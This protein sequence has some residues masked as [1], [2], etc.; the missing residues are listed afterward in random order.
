MVGMVVEG[1]NAI[2]AAMAMAKEYDVELPIV[3][4]VDAVVNHGAD[5]KE[6][7]NKLMMREKKTEL[8][9]GR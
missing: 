6:T 8:I 3:F 1:I 9:Y 5:P 4:A 2:P 7:V